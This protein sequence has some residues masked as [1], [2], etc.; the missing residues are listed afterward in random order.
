MTT[1]TWLQPSPIGPLRVTSGDDGICRIDL[2]HGAAGGS[3]T[4]TTAEPADEAVAEALDRYF[5]GDVAAL[6]GLTVDAPG[7]EFRSRIWA[8]LRRIPPGETVT[9]AELARRAGHDPRAARAVGGAVGAN[10]VP[11][12]V[13]CHR[14]VAAGGKL[15]G[16]AL[17]VDVKRRLL[18][19]E[20]ATGYS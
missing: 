11:I 12:V 19:L 9:Y 7:S 17:G 14:V 8:E 20:G 3:A 13:P 10:P 6:D 4:G 5:G 2:D 16:F 18:D 15:G 1:H